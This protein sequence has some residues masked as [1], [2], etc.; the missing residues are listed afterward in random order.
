[1]IARWPESKWRKDFT[2]PYVQI[3]FGARQTGKSTLIRSLLPEGATVVDLSD[4]RERGLYLNDPGRFITLCRSLPARGPATWVFVDEAQS[5]PS[6]FDSVQ[7]LYDREKQRWH[8]ILCGSS[9]RKL[10]QT[11]AN[12]LPGRSFL[13]RL[14]PLTRIERP[15]PNP[16]SLSMGLRHWHCRG[17]KKKPRRACSRP[18]T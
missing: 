8:F 12:L 1:M 3:V 16:R 11:G 4:P 10:R 18:P 14:F 6:I 17:P 2:R 13:H 7:H 9:A 5:V 15:P